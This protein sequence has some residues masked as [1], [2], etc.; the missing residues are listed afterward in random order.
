MHFYNVLQHEI[1]RNSPA[2][3][4]FGI[5]GRMTKLVQFTWVSIFPVR[6]NSCIPWVAKVPTIAQLCLKKL[7]LKPYGPGDFWLEI[8][9]IAFLISSGET[10]TQRSSCCEIVSCGP[11]AKTE[12]C[13][14]LLCTYCCPRKP[15]QKLTMY[16]ATLALPL[17]DSPSVCLNRVNEWL[18]SSLLHNGKEIL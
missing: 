13:A 7:L 2:P 14:L 18:L 6:K 11:Y 17:I 8:A 9:N 5:F 4:G 10:S 16:S 1:G 3:V 12:S 15:L